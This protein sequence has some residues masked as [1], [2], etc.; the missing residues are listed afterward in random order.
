MNTSVVTRLDP[1][2]FVKAVI[3]RP[4]DD[5]VLAYTAMLS[6][7]QIAAIVAR[8]CRKLCECFQIMLQQ[9]MKQD[10]DEGEEGVM[11]DM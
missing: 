4:T 3:E 10:P 8:A 5:T 6:F 9:L 11:S 7:P 1:G 2:P